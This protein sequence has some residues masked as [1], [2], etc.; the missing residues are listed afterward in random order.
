MRAIA[1]CLFVVLTGQALAGSETCTSYLTGQREKMIEAALACEGTPSQTQMVR[2]QADAER[3]GEKLLTFS[4][5]S[6]PLSVVKSTDLFSECVRTH[7][8]AAQ[9]Y[10]C[11]IARTNVHSTVKEC[12]NATQTCKVTDPIPQ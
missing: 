4:E 6:R 5:C 7:L 8:C 12:G 9:T 10:A 1:L 2:G 3:N 11:A